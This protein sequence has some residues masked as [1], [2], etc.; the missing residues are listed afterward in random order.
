MSEPAKIEQETWDVGA[1]RIA[2]VYAEALL[3]AAQ[4]QDQVEA[5]LDELDSLVHVIAGDAR[6][7]TLFSSSA[8]GRKAREGILAKTFQG[9]TSEM[10]Y[11]FLLVL[12]D[13]ERLDLLRAVNSAIR[14][15]HDER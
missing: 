3:N 1:R 7:A 4:Q 6:I 15:L 12:N 13:H 5:I 9:R 14:A 8:L 11:H 10:F 2:R